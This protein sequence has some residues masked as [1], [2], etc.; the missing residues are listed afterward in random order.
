[1]PVSTTSRDAT[2]EER[3]VIARRMALKRRAAAGTWQSR[4]GELRGLGVMF[5]SLSL[6]LAVALVKWPSVPLGFGLGTCATFATLTV[7]GR[8]KE[9]ARV[10]E[11]SSALDRAQAE[12]ER[13]VTE[14]RVTTD[15]IVTAAGEDGDVWWLFRGE[16]GKWLVVGH[17]QWDDLDADARSW[18]RDVAIAFDGH[19]CAVSIASAGPPIAVERRDLQPPDY[20]PTPDTL[21]W[22]PPDNTGPAPALIVDSV[23]V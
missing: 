22:S 8:R 3:A 20:L 15:R 17:D 18:N 14:Y 7:I 4:A 19:G 9:R 16:D 2:E 23:P 10:A 12:R 13:T 1:M 11:E 21:F 5:G 6:G